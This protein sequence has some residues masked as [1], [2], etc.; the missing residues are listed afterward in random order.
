MFFNYSCYSSS[1]VLINQTG[2]WDPDFIPEDWHIFLQSFFATKGHVTITPIFLPT[3]VD[4]PEGKN[5]FDAIKNRYQQCLRHAWGATDIAY[6]IE[7]SR[8]HTDIPLITRLL[9]IFKLV[10][11][12]FIWSSNW[13]ILTLGTSLPVLLNPRFFQTSIGY[14]LPRISNVI[15]SLCLIPLFVLIVLDWKLRPDSKNKNFFDFLKNLI[16]WP[17]MPVATLVLSVLPGLHSHT[18]LMLGKRIEYKT[19]IKKGKL[20]K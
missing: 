15:L 8:I 18:R 11:T 9:R 12:H 1:F 17:L 4:A 10:E 2:Y 19:T 20:T 13:F 16:Y 3:V 5:Y 7:Q 6:A 14:N